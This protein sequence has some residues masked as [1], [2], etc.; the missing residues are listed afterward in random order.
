MAYIS[1]FPNTRNYDQDLG[2]LIC[3]YKKLICKYDNL[4]LSYDELKQIYNTIKNDI[5][6]ITEDQLKEWL[7]DGTLETLLT[8][9]LETYLTDLKNFVIDVV[10]EL[11]NNVTSAGINQLI[12]DHQEATLFFRDGTYEIDEPILLKNNSIIGGKNTIFINQLANTPQNTTKALFSYGLD[13]EGIPNNRTNLGACTQYSTYTLTIPTLV[14][15]QVEVG[16]LIGSLG[17]VAR[18]NAIDNSTHVITV[19]R[20]IEYN[21]TSQV[22]YKFNI[23]YTVSIEGVTFNMNNRYGFG[24]KIDGGSNCRINNVT[25]YNWG[26]RVIEIGHTIDSIV[27]NC[28][29]NS[30]FDQGE[31]LGYGIRVDESDSAYVNNITGIGTRHTVDVNVSHHTT[32]SN[33]DSYNCLNPYTTHSNGSHYTKFINCNAYGSTNFA[34]GGL[35][36]GGDIK[37]EIKNSTIQNSSFCQNSINYDDNIT[38]DSCNFI[39]A[40]VSGTG[41]LVITNSY[42][43]YDRSETTTAFLRITSALDATIIN[44]KIAFSGESIYDTFSGNNIITFSNCIMILNAN[45]TMFPIGTATMRVLNSQV[46]ITGTDLLFSGAGTV[47]IENS[48]IKAGAILRLTQS[49]TNVIL[50]SNTLENIQLFN[51]TIASFI[52]NTNKFVNC[53]INLS[54]VT[55]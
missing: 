51:N 25:G 12:T 54:L 47:D 28:N 46:D 6:N 36:S 39:N 4:E 41:H 50:L 20:P 27:E 42:I 48:V 11:D 13:A 10:H 40:T 37:T 44:C 24:L 30:A 1:E 43:D 22:I 52:F 2:Q 5:T 34:F 45:A 49:Q 21:I 18:V 9:A 17:F 53:S 8:E 14:A 55:S 26:S 29:F 31:G 7:E 23:D 19:D 16:D 3:M 35:N 38:I 15:N 33:C 32:V